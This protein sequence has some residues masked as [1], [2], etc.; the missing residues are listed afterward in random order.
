[1]KRGKEVKFEIRM[2]N[3]LESKHAKEESVCKETEK[4]NEGWKIDHVKMKVS[5]KTYIKSFEK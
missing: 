2:K 4:E 5:K 3:V 1:M